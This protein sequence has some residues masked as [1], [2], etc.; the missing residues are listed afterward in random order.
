M[1]NNCPGVNQIERFL[2]EEFESGDE[3]K[4]W[5]SH[6]ETCELCQDSFY[7]HQELIRNLGE[8]PI[9]KL[10]PVFYQ[11]L[12]AALDKKKT[13]AVSTRWKRLLLQGYWLFAFGASF[14]ILDSLEGPV[15]IPSEYLFALAISGTLALLIFRFAIKKVKVGFFD[16]VDYAAVDPEF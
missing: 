4:Q 6:L 11:E 12:R 16:L 9:P 14:M 5:E 1:A 3:L 10:S 8:L 13:V 7:G 2:E 15:Q